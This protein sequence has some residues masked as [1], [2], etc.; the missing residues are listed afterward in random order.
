MNRDPWGS[1]CSAGGRTPQFMV[2]SCLF[3]AVSKMGS[4]RGANGVIRPHLEP[5]ECLIT[6]Q[7]R[8]RKAVSAQ[9]TALH[10]H[11]PASL[12]IIKQRRTP[13]RDRLVI[14]HH[15]RARAVLTTGVHPT[16]QPW[17]RS[18]LTPLLF[19]QRRVDAGDVPDPVLAAIAIVT[20]VK[21]GHGHAPIGCLPPAEPSTMSSTGPLADPS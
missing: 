15:T 14:A 6:A 18:T 1:G 21:N 2:L 20:I 16:H 12:Q 7:M 10:H 13:H 8:I 9:V 19:Q 4:D 3:T 11:R 5:V 17:I